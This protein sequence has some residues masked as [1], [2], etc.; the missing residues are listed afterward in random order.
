MV[1]RGMLLAKFYAQKYPNQIDTRY[2]YTAIWASPFRVVNIV[3][4]QG[5]NNSF[6]QGATINPTYGVVKE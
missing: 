4:L 3:E 2:T 5:K 6:A 1:T